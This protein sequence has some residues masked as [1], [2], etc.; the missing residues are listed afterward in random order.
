MYDNASLPRWLS[1][2]YSSTSSKASESCHSMVSSSRRHVFD[3]ETWS[4]IYDMLVSTM[5]YDDEAVSDLS[6][7][8]SSI[9]SLDRFCSTESASLPAK[10]EQQ[11]NDTRPFTAAVHQISLLLAIPVVSMH[12]TCVNHRLAGLDLYDRKRVLPLQRCPST[13]RRKLSR[14]HT[15]LV[16]ECGMETAAGHQEFLR[17]I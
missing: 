8:S 2:L 6:G 10:K 5:L 17:G 13:E 12:A 14:Y 11:S 9:V 7:R 15:S 3:G 1:A 16:L 4:W